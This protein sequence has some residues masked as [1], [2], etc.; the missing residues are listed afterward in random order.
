M[1]GSILKEITT[2]NAIL[3]SEFGGNVPLGLLEKCIHCSLYMYPDPKDPPWPKLHDRRW[4]RCQIINEFESN[5]LLCSTTGGGLWRK[6]DQAV[7]KAA[8]PRS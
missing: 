1:H 2:N 3:E 7:L 8:F 4:K 6:G 5:F